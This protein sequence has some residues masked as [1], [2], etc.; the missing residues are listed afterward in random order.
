MCWTWVFCPA[1]AKQLSQ[2]NDYSFIKIYM[3]SLSAALHEHRTGQKR[4][5]AVSL[6]PKTQLHDK[7]FLDFW[8]WNF[9]EKIVKNIFQEFFPGLFGEETFR[10][11]IEEVIFLGFFNTLGIAQNTAKTYW[12]EKNQLFIK[13][14]PKQKK[15]VFFWKKIFLLK[16]RASYLILVLV[17]KNMRRKEMLIFWSY[18]VGKQSLWLE[19]NLLFWTFLS[20]SA[21]NQRCLFV[22]EK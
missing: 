7:F 12:R 21:K 15:L 10:K 1:N 20:Q 2:T 18:R 4:V 6:A 19:G 11:W 16:V 3:K 14:L 17:F 9:S 5:G 8:F 22:V 13:T